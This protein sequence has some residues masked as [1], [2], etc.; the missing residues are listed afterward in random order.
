MLAWIQFFSH[1]LHTDFHRCFNLCFIF[2]AFH[3]VNV[4]LWP[5]KGFAL[6]QAG[7]RRENAR[8]FP[9]NGVLWARH[10]YPGNQKFHFVVLA[11]LA[12]AVA[13][14]G[15]TLNLPPRSGNALG[16]Q[17]FVNVIS[18]MAAPPDA[19]RE[20]WIYAQVE[21]GNI[22]D[23]MRNLVPITTNL[24]ISGVNHTVTYYAAPEYLAIG[25]DE[26]YFLEPMT[27][28][29]AQR[30]SVLLNCTLPTQKM[31]DDIWTQT[32][33][34]LAPMP[35]TYNQ[36]NPPITVAW[37]DVYNSNIWAQREP[38]IPSFPL[39]DSVAGDKKDVI[40]STYIYNNLQNGVTTP[41]VIYGW[42]YTDG[43]PIQPIYNGHSEYYMDYSHGIRMV[44]QA[45]TVDGQPTTVTN[46]L[47]N[48]NLAALLSD[49]TI[50]AGN[51]IPQPYYT[52]GETAPVIITQPYSQSVQ[53]GATVIFS[54][55]AV[56]DP[57]LTYQWKRNGQGISSGTNQT[58][59]LTNVTGANAGTYTVVVNN[60]TATPATS[61]PAFLLVSS[62]SFPVLFSDNFDTDT[63]GNWTFLWGA[64]DN[65]PDY[66]TNWAY[67]YGQISY[68]YN[69]TTYLI[70]PAPNSTNGTTLGVKFTVN[71]MN[72]SDAGVN[73]YPRSQHFSGNYAFKFDMWIN[74]PGNA[75]GG[76]ASGTTQYA[77]YGLNFLGTEVNWGAASATSTD[78]IWF[79]NDG[80]G[81]AIQDYL[82]F[83]GNTSGTQIE[84]EG[85]TAAGLSQSNH[86]ASIFT[87][88]FPTPPSETTGTPGK[89]WATVEIDQTNNNLIW[90]MNGTVIA[91]RTNTSSFTAGNVMLG[92]MDIFPSLANPAS[93]CYV[94]YD[95]VSVLNLSAAPTVAPNVTTNPQ[96]AST[97]PGK[98]ASFSVG[99]SG[100]APLTYQWFLNGA[101][102]AGATNS[103]LVVSN[104]QPSGAGQYYAQVSNG[105]GSALSGAATLAISSNWTMA[106]P[107]IVNNIFQFTLLGLTNQSYIIDFSTNLTVWTP[108][109]TNIPGLF[110]DSSSSNYPVRFYRTRPMP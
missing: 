80:D 2:A 76:G 95:N 66:T 100:T 62:N 53:Q 59:T 89:T 42:Q 106:A 23:W 101:P 12:C 54:T 1:R 25:S 50:F 55:L 32:Q 96:P 104:A 88:L 35:L 17:A 103:T 43:V 102:V 20:N 19:Q 98:S 33:L 61:L 82:A 41:V 64:N 97:D 3:V 6:K 28:L 84:L 7:F 47:T 51:V 71:N 78:G 93:Q 68:T 69:G 86:T 4:D 72:G 18:P 74:Y 44:Q 29:L 31:V 60:E 36:T 38:Y 99:A 109:Q 56:G 85:P 48:P 30:I 70:P 105:A 52:V 5:N 16:G 49:E 37:F 8:S 67:D 108:L 27:P 81:G 110:M 65:L 22:P 87:S 94:L 39:G 75:E 77:I 45:I 90:K 34:K 14:L 40:I 92:L 13:A 107:R 21:S 26:D 91:Q 15:Q 24:V 79:G 57:P 11:W 73:I 46:V 83:V 10:V 9:A 63:S 58:L